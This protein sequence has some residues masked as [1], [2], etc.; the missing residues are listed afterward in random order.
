MS[1]LVEVPESA[2]ASELRKALDEVGREIGVEVRVEP[3][4]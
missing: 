1:L 3:A 2:E 4:G